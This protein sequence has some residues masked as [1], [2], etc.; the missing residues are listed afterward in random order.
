MIY[1][2]PLRLRG[3]RTER[4]HRRPQ[5]QVIIMSMSLHTHTLTHILVAWLGQ[6]ASSPDP[7]TG[8]QH[9]GRISG[10]DVAC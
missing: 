8:I 4:E 7:D 5:A 3:E 1:T 10:V 2:V 9:G 6:R